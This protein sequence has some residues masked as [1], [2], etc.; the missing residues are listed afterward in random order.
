MGV[1][2]S[3]HSVGGHTSAGFGCRSRRPN[4][5]RKRNTWPG[6]WIPYSDFGLLG[7]HVDHVDFYLR[8]R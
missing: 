4:W 8:F 6:S 2:V 1:H 7:V 3:A 5:D